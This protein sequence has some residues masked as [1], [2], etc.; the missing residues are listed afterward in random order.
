MRHDSLITKA[1]DKQQPERRADQR[2]SEAN[3]SSSI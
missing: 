3:S 2:M 1:D